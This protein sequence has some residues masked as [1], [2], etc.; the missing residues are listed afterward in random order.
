MSLKGSSLISINDLT[1]EDIQY[2]F[3]WAGFFKTAAQNKISLENV[4][5]FKH[6]RN[7]TVF[8]VFAEASTRTRTSFEI[9]CHRLGVNVVNFSDLKN[10]SLAKG[11]SLEATM[12]ALDALGASAIVLR[13]KGRKFQSDC[14]TPIINAGFGSYEHPTQALIDAWTIQQVRGKVKGEKVLI[15]G[16]VLHSRVSNSNLKLLRKLGAEVALCSPSALQPQDDFWQGV[17]CF[18]N[19]NEGIRWASVIM[20]LRIQTERHDDSVGLS[21]ASYRDYYLVG[22]EHL[23]MFHKDGVL[24]HP[25]PYICG[26]EISPTVFDDSRCH[27]ITQ[28]KNAPFIRAAILTRVLNLELKE[29]K[30]P[31]DGKK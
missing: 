2:I 13:Y 15:V 19:L 28:V 27:I 25:G 6:S 18:K 4:V 29:D 1:E 22:Q 5:D 12:T 21:I 11:E 20:C 30:L 8:L 16:D 14:G 9:A 10:S 26:V 17:H 3:H 24:I 7:H 23:K 31:A